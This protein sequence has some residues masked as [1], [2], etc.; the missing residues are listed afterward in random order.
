MGFELAGAFK[1]LPPT[2]HALGP[3]KKKNVRNYAVGRCEA[4]SC[5]A[6]FESI[7]GKLFCWAVNV[8]PETWVIEDGA[9]DLPPLYRWKD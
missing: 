8:Y 3:P 2:P 6:P 1:H 4:E 5:R 7:S 9:G